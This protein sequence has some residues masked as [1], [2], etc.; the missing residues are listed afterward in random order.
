MLKP[1]TSVAQQEDISLFQKLRFS[2]RPQRCVPTS[3]AGAV[4][5][6]AERFLWLNCNCWRVGVRAVE[7]GAAFEWHQVLKSKPIE[8]KWMM[9]TRSL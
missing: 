8:T 2:S 6:P 3:V 1:R 7:F 5:N 9:T 4:A